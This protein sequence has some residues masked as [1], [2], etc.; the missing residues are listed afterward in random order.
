MKICK[1]CNSNLDD[2]L[3]GKDSSSKDGLKLT[4]KAC[5]RK[6]AEIYRIN[7]KDIVN[8]R[9]NEHYHKNK[10]K[11]K[12]YSENNKEILKEKKRIYYLNNKDKRKEYSE[13]NK[14]KRNLK[15][16]LINDKLYRIKNSIRSSIGRSIRKKFHVKSL[17]T[18]DILGLPFLDFYFYIESKFESW[19]NWNNYGLYNGQLNYGWDIDHIIPIGVANTEEDLVRLNHY[20]NLQP[21]CSKINRDIKKDNYD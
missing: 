4:C 10:D 12:E 18:Q 7:N 20:T 9:S 6:D 8:K 16:R 21:L 1:K 2:S 19:M 3:F 17:K 5:L 11:R 15:R 14:E 13:N